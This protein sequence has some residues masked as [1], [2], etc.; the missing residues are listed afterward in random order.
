MAAPLFFHGLDA[1]ADKIRFH[2]IVTTL[3]LVHLMVPHQ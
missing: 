1:L 2:Q 3:A